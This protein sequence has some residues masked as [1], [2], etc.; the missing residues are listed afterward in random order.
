MS[1]KILV[2][3]SLCLLIPA[4]ALV[5]DPGNVYYGLAKDFLGRD[6]KPEDNAEVALIR[7]EAGKEIVLARS[8]ILDLNGGSE[9]APV[10]V[11][12]VLRPALDDGLAARFDPAAGRKEDPV[13][14]YVIHNGVR[15]ETFSKTGGCAP[16]SDVVPALGERGTIRKI[17]FRC[18]DDWDGDCIA[19]S[20]ERLH[21]SST[22]FRGTDDWDNDG[23]ND[24]AEFV[25]GSDPLKPAL[26]ATMAAL[27]IPAVRITMPRKD[28]AKIEWA[29]QSGV[30]YT[31][32]WSGTLEGFEPVPPERM[33]GAAGD[34]VNVAGMSKRFF[35]I[36]L[37]RE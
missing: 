27:E 1:A 18:I 16:V 9:A 8:P 30:A 35:R 12:Y 17:D 32:E 24:L 33:G 26:Q 34:E 22:A 28:I 19:D 15:Y 6:L 11:N 20:W 2:L 36:R 13:A 31:I 37:A 23:L 5:P 4:Q 7:I 14:I 25:R 29:R 3:L 21:F 10:R